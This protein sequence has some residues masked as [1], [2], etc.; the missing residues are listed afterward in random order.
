MLLSATQGNAKQACA[1]S[2]IEAVV[3]WSCYSYC[4]LI[5]VLIPSHLLL[6]TVITYYAVNFFLFFYFLRAKASDVTTEIVC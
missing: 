1:S 6:I 2:W 4:W 5:V 3:N